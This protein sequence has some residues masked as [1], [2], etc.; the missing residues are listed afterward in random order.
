VGGWALVSPRGFYSSFP[1]QAQHWISR[2]GAFDEHLI[3]DYGSMSVAL[4]L[5]LACAAI[6]LERR[7]STVALAAWLVWASPHFLYHALNTERLT[8]A[9]NIANLASL[10]AS[11]I[12]PLGLLVLVWRLPT[13]L[14]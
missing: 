2:L 5:V 9:G 11:V 12:V 6:A 3:V 7:L 4:T 10:S 13:R 14:T 8:T 1:I